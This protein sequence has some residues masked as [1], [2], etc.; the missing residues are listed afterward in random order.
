MCCTSLTQILTHIHTHTHTR[1]QTAT[2]AMIGAKSR[3]NMITAHQASRWSACS[4]PN[5]Y[6]GMHVHKS[7]W[8]TSQQLTGGAHTLPTTPCTSV[9]SFESQATSPSRMAQ[10]RYPKR[11]EPDA[12]ERGTP[13]LVYSK[14]STTSHPICARRA[15][16]PHLPISPNSRRT[17]LTKH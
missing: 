11:L 12:R 15:S 6:Q 13:V 3:H 5:Q 16:P 2:Q 14:T 17:L 1:C 10:L 9:Q 8:F 4:L 7:R